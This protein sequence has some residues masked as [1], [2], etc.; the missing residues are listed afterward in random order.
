MAKK[1]EKNTK[2]THHLAVNKVIH[3]KNTPQRLKLYVEYIVTAPSKISHF[4]L[5][6]VRVRNRTFQ[7]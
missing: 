7:L 4:S 6:G 3:V 1:E 5:G 2:R